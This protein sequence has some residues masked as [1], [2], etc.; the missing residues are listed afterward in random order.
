[1]DNSITLR[2]GAVAIIR[3][4]VP[5]YLLTGALLLPVVPP[6][7]S[8]SALI[9]LAILV[10]RLIWAERLRVLPLRL[11]IF[12]SI[13]FTGYLMHRDHA[14]MVL[15]PSVLRIGLLVVLLGLMFVVIRSTKD[16]T[17]QTTPTDLLVIALAGGAGV[18][19]QQGMLEAT[20]VP[21][22]LGIVVLFYAAELIMRRMEQTWNCFTLGMIG[23]LTV[24][25]LRLL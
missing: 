8:A 20:L 17:F 21:V 4:C 2:R 14:V 16:Q 1:M 7:I 12:P 23:V 10:V 11:L 6:D 9:I 22:V 19:Y 24:L 18:L 15:L 13:A 3:C 5:A 25:S